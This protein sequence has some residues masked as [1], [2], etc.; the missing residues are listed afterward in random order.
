[1]LLAIIV[2]VLR[3]SELSLGSNCTD[4]ESNSVP[5]IDLS[6]AVSVGEFTSPPHCPGLNCAE[7]LAFSPT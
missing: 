5:E 4:E 7:M 1:M 6:D 3:F 2:T